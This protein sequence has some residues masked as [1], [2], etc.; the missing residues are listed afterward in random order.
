V[1]GFIGALVLLFSGIAAGHVLWSTGNI[2]FQ[3]HN[4]PYYECARGQAGIGHYYPGG[5]PDGKA[6]V[7]A[8]DQ[9]TGCVHPNVRP[10]GWLGATFD[11]HVLYNAQNFLCY[12]GTWAYNPAWQNNF[13]VGGIQCTNW[14]GGIFFTVAHSAYFYNGAWAYGETWSPNHDL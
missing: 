12:Q 5:W 9:N 3:P 13:G 2:F 11:I 14:G 4:Y 6:Y 7:F 1:G 10:T 8:Y